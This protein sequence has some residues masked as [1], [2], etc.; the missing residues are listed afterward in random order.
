MTTEINVRDILGLRKVQGQRG[1][2][3]PNSRGICA[4]YPKLAT[5]GEK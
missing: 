5:I 3:A 1:T 4:P 2:Y